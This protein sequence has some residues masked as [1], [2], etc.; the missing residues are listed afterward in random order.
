MYF[1]LLQVL[2]LSFSLFCMPRYWL[3]DQRSQ[4]ITTSYSSR[5]LLLTT[6]DEFGNVVDPNTGQVISDTG[7]RFAAEPPPWKRQSPVAYNHTRH[8]HG[9]PDTQGQHTDL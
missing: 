7:G 5:T 1:H 6:A 4:G 3:D 2:L 9:R 8:E